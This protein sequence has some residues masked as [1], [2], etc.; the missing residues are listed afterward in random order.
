M[1]SAKAYD[2]MY[3]WWAPWDS[4]GVRGDLRALLDSGRVSP[5]T[6]PRTVDLGCGT[7]ANVVHLAAEGFESWGVDFSEVALHKAEERR[8]AAGVEAHFVRGDLT[9]ASIDGVDGP[10]DLIVDFGTLDDLR[11]EDQLA[12]IATI[13][14]L[15]QPGTLFLCFCFFGEKRDLPL[16]SLEAPARWMPNPTIR[17][18]Q[19]EAWFGDRWD[20]EVFNAYEGEPYATF[21]LEKKPT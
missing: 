9:G 4:V 1:V 5:E 10:F 3:R 21:L 7:G 18:G 6:H 14:R 2:A 8:A 12:M 13:D 20:V 15:S 17:P 16:F 19:M 11:G